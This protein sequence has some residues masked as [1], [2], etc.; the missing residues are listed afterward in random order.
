MLKSHLIASN[1][2]IVEALEALNR[3]S[4]ET[5]TLFVTD[6]GSRL[7]G[8]LTDGDIRR[9]LLAGHDL[10][11]NVKVICK[12]DCLRL[13]EGN[14]EI[15]VISEARKK[16]VKL[17][18]VVNEGII[19]SLVDLRYQ[20]GLIPADG[21]LMAGGIGERLKPLTESV[22]KPLLPVGDRPI[23][24]RNVELM[25]DFGIRKIF[26]TVNYL[27]QK[28]IDHFAS[29]CADS[30]SYEITCVE[31][32]Q[33][34]GT[35]GSLSLIES[36]S[37]PNIVVMNADLLTDINLEDMYLKHIETD[38]WLT[39]AVVPYVVSVPYAIVEHEGDKVEGLTEKPTYNF[40]A[41]AGIYMLRR[42]AAERIPGNQYMDAPDLIDILLREGRRVSQYKIDGRWI[43]IGSPDDYR[44][45]C[46]IM[47]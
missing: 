47:K 3:L 26:V 41:N 28:L 27:K 18:P 23:I 4:G 1:A 12:K 16:R 20:R 25:R 36:F 32:P 35:I 5:M 38:A 42:V 2:S 37:S 17:L 21:V 43:D 39:M 34:L 15:S 9:A 22:P 24:D 13:S 33:K 44:H 30:S 8:S 40:Y 11:D 7:I 45:A 46:E 10:S 19:V 6:E 14:Y 31:E 29:E